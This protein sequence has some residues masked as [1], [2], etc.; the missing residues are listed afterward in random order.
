[1]TIEEMKKAFISCLIVMVCLFLLL[2]P[3]VYVVRHFLASVYNNLEHRLFVLSLYANPSVFV[4][5]ARYDYNRGRFDLFLDDIQ[6]GLSLCSE[7]NQ[8]KSCAELSRILS[9]FNSGLNLD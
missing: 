6:L 9:N 3:G 8:N 2:Y 5:F 7:R 4:K 1:M